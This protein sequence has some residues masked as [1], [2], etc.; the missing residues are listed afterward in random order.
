MNIVSAQKKIKMRFERSRALGM[1]FERNR[2]TKKEYI[3][4]CMWI[5][6]IN[7]NIYIKKLGSVSHN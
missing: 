7:I 6:S 4:V 2:A 3:A 1:S 5:K